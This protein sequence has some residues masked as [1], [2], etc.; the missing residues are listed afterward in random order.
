MPYA[1]DEATLPERLYV[2]IKGGSEARQF[3]LNTFGHQGKVYYESFF[4]IVAMQSTATDQSDL[5]ESQRG[6]E[7][8]LDVPQGTAVI[9]TRKVILYMYINY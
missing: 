6:V 9:L 8:V 2:Q 3:D 4:Y 5:P 7:L 1:W